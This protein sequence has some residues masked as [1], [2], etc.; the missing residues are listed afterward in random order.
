MSLTMQTFLQEQE[1]VTL[2]LFGPSVL[3]IYTLYLRV[4]RTN[5]ALSCLAK[6]KVCNT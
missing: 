5:R 2:N 3:V 1:Q 4:Q 6:L